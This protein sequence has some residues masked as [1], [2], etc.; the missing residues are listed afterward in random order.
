MLHYDYNFAIVMNYNV[1]IWYAGYLILTLVKGLVSQ[2][3]ST[4]KLR[5]SALDQGIH[6]DHTLMVNGSMGRGTFKVHNRHIH[7]RPQDKG[8]LSSLMSNSMQ[9]H[10]LE[11]L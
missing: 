10:P 6:G 1:N 5:I 3:E 9:S 2:K 8:L 11:F 4:H 7:N